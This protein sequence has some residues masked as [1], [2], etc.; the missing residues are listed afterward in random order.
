[1]CLSTLYTRRQAQTMVRAD[2]NQPLLFG[3][4]VVRR[5]RHPSMRPT[6]DLV[7]KKG[8]RIVRERAH[9]NIPMTGIHTYE[10]G[11]HVYMDESRAKTWAKVFSEMAIKVS[12]SQR[13]V[14]AWGEGGGCLCAVVKAVKVLT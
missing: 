9:H 1:M 5:N 13:S 12:F 4:K 2:L 6:S 7:Y 11:I 8:R 3:W 10:A 14:V